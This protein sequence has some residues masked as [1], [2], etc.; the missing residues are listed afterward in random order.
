MKNLLNRYPCT[1]LAVV[2]LATGLL[3]T[4]C[5][6]VDQS[7]GPSIDPAKVAMIQ[8]GKTTRA[9]IEQWFGKPDNVAIMPD[10]RRAITYTHTSMKVA[11]QVNP[12]NMVL[13]VFS[14]T[15]KASQRMQTLQIYLSKEEIVD[16]F[17]F[18]DNTSHSEMDQWGNRRTTKG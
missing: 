8:K 15:T 18:N 2:A 14:D 12:L 6:T 7:S 13:P 1:T 17:E 11:A 5:A 10:G 16:D 3:L 4:G 9:E